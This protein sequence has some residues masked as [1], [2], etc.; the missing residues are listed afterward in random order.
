MRK[1]VLLAV[2]GALLCG[3][4]GTSVRADDWPQWLGPK[5]DGVWRETGI[6]DKF[7]ADGPKVRW[8][9]SIGAGF[10]GPAVAEGKVYLIDRVLAEG[11]KLPASPFDTR[12][13]IPGK[14]RVLALSEDDGRILWTYEYECP[15]K[16]SYASGPRAT[17]LVAGG[18]VYTLGTEGNLV[19]LDATSGKVQW[20]HE[21]K[22]DYG[23]KTPYWGFSAHPLLDGQ[24]LICMVGGKGTTVAA[25]DKDSGKEMWRALSAKQPGYCPPMIYEAGGQRQ[26]VVWDSEAVHGMNPETGSVY[27]T[28]PLDSYSGMSI[29][30]PRKEGDELFLTGYDGHSLMLRLDPQKPAA[31]VVWQGTKKKGMSSVFSTPFFEGGYIYGNNA[32]KDDSLVCIKAE[33]G[34]ILW[35]TKKP[36]KDA[37]APSGDTFIVKNGDRFFLFAEQGDLIIAN[38][39]PKG[40][41]E[42]SRAHVLEPTTAVSGGPLKNRIVVWSHPAFANKCIFARNDKEIVCVSLAAERN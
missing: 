27:W 4:A 37:A 15:Y 3:V 26:L 28:Q 35:Q 22:K 7:P 12:N 33:T 17:P 14:E 20:A 5:R 2:I 9:T 10:A 24:K 40:Y 41:E 11:A 18:K 34:E 1:I 25:F 19:C 42:I 38:L 8:R 16:V 23:A 31:A 29:S 21:L 32:G 36:N 13:A 30:T 39:S 6:V